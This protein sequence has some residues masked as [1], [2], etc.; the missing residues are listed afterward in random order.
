MNFNFYWEISSFFLDMKTGRCRN[1]L[2]SWPSLA[3]WGLQNQK[4]LGAF[5]KLTTTTLARAYPYCFRVCSH[6]PLEWLLLIREFCWCCFSDDRQGN[7]EPVQ[8]KLRENLSSTSL[9]AA[10]LIVKRAVGTICQQCCPVDY[11]C[12]Y[13]LPLAMLSWSSSHHPPPSTSCCSCSLISNF[14]CIVH[15]NPSFG[16]PLI[17]SDI[18]NS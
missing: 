1:D 7:T 6:R 13:K 16:L 11:S 10:A 2:V 4:G 9:A 18:R 8:G 3:I 17:H 12:C 14:A 5:K 15:M